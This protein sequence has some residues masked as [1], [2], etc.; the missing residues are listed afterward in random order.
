MTGALGATVSTVA[1]TAAVVVMLPALSVALAVKLWLPSVSAQ[2]GEVPVASNDRRRTEVG[3]TVKHVHRRHPVGV[4]HR[5]RQR[6]RVV[7][8]QPAARDRRGRAGIGA[9]R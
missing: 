6:Q 1:V 9:D 3:R 2:G 7:V 5:A 8:G 4:A